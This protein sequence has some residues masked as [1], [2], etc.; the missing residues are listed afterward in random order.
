MAAVEHQPHRRYSPATPAAGHLHR[1]RGQLPAPARRQRSQLEEASSQTGR[2]GPQQAKPWRWFGL[3]DQSRYPER[4][5][6]GL[7]D[8]YEFVISKGAPPLSAMANRGYEFE[9]SR[10]VVDSQF[11]GLVLDLS[12][13]THEVRLDA[14]LSRLPRC[15]VCRW[16][17]HCPCRKDIPCAGTLTRPTTSIPRT[18]GSG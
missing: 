18:P 10:A 12:N 15:L 13:P 17:L 1:G 9:Q 5:A 4:F 7:R 11:V 2:R 6:S 16:A 8:L 14:W 3:G